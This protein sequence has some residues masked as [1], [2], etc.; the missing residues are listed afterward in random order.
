MTRSTFSRNA[1]TVSLLSLTVN[2][3]NVLRGSFNAGYMVI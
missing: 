3:L 1:F 2:V